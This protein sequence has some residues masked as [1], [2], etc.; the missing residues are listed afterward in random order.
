MQEQRFRR[1]GLPLQYRADEFLHMQ[2]FG[3]V[4]NYAGTAFKFALT[5]KYNPMPKVE[6]I[7]Y[8]VAALHGFM[9]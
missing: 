4:F 8:A 2:Y 7:L 9:I 3:A 5:S 6:L 1:Q